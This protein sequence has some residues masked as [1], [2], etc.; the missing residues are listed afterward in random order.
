MA[1]IDKYAKLWPFKIGLAFV[2]NSSLRST[3]VD[4]IDVLS[5]QAY[6]KV[7]Q[8]KTVY[9]IIVAVEN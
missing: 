7:Q 1:M 6:D 9:S 3:T 5:A 4:N 8:R 2:E